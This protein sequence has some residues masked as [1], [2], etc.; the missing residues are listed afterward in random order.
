MF[1]GFCKAQEMKCF[2]KFQ[3][4]SKTMSGQGITLTR[5]LGYGVEIALFMLF[6]LSY[7]IQILIK[8]YISMKHMDNF[9]LL[10]DEIRKD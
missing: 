2:K 5:D 4:E 3:E 7:S 9:P 8:P 6:S 1:L 10:Q